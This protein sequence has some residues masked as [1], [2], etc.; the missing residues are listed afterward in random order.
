MMDGM[1][2]QK[3]AVTIPQETL[4]GARRAVRSGKAKSLSAYVSR[5][6]EQKTMFD[7]LDS[8]L[9]ELLRESGGPLTA[10]EKRSAD[11]ILIGRAPSKRRRK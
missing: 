10:S 11:S 7:D 5:A 4:A 8:L 6:L 3:I 1:T 9:D 2:T